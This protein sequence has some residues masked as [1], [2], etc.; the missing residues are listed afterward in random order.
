MEARVVRQG[1][2]RRVSRLAAVA[3]GGAALLLGGCST[4][5]QAEYDDAIAE[6]NDLRERVA[7]LQDTVRQSN[8]QKSA[9]Q[10]ENRTLAGELSGLRR[11]LEERQQQRA[12]SGFEGIPGVTVGGGPGEVILGVEGDVLFASGSATLQPAARQSLDRVASV[13]RQRYPN[14]TIRVEGHTDS[15]P[16]RR[17]NWKSNE[18]LSFERALAVQSYLLE[19]GLERRRVYAA[20]F[21]PSRPKST[22]RESRRV[23]IV[24]IDERR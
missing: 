13:I 11:Q 6:N 22:K 18:H 2:M 10:N 9:L 5:S 4:V 14:Q 1:V 8:D 19:R 16:I 21:G 15:D 23:E 7:S 24:I 12:D 3:A 17:S 20:G